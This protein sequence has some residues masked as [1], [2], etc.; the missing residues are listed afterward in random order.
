MALFLLQVDIWD[1]RKVFGSRARTLREELL[2][3]DPPT[4]LPEQQVKPSHTI[5]IVTL[6]PSL[7]FSSTYQNMVWIVSRG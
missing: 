7:P 3:D 4:D 5:R 2:G 6:F 1:E